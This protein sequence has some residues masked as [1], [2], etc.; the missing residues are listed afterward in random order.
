MDLSIFDRR[1]NND[2]TGCP[3][4]HPKLLLKVVL[5]AY[6][7]GIVGSRRIEQLCRKHVTCMALACGYRPDHRTIAA[8]VSSMPPEIR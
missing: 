1:Y 2:A 5:F 4:Y 3:A 8:F 7:L 6:S